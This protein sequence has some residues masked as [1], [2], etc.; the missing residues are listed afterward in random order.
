MWT[1]ANKT[2]LWWA[3]GMEQYFFAAPKIYETI[4]VDPGR[5]FQKLRFTRANIFSLLKLNKISL[6]I[7]GK[8]AHRIQYSDTAKCIVYKNENNQRILWEFPTLRKGLPVY[9][10]IRVYLYIL[11]YVWGHIYQTVHFYNMQIVIKMIDRKQ[12]NIKRVIENSFENLIQQ[13]R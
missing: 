11:A 12:I 8:P 9:V 6:P 1:R 5:L 10:C 3:E 7:S 13:S 4:P 2:V